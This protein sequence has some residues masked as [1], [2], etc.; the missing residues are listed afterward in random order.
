VL[1]P[2]LLLEVGA[3]PLQPRFQRGDL[4]VRLHVLDREGD[5]VGGLLEDPR[6]RLGVSVRGRAGDRQGADRS[7]SRDQRNDDVGPDAV[8]VRAV[9][10]R[11]RALAG[12]V[13]AQ[14]EPLLAEDLAHVTLVG[15]HL[16][17]DA[18]VVGGERRRQHEE[19]EH[20]A[21]GVVEEDRGALEGHDAA[22]GPGDGLEERV[23]GQVRD[24]GVVDLEERA[25]PLRVERGPIG[26]GRG[27]HGA[28]AGGRRQRQDR[29]AP[30]AC[31]SARRPRLEGPNGLVFSPDERSLYVGSLDPQ[32]K[33]GPEHPHN[34]AW[35]ERST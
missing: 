19:P 33:V 32:R 23:S 1:A 34:L 29:R 21:L 2:D 35:G 8:G 18:E 7:P 24:D 15:R 3:L 26:V 12:E 14:P 16:E 28:R 6:V 25:K 4:L 31:A 22:E 13:S 30:I 10:H 9:F 27:L 11:V 5:L 17:A 20:V